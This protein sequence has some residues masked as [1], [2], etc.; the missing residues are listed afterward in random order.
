VEKLFKGILA[1]FDV[2]PEEHHD[3]AR[4]L[5]Q[6]RLLDRKTADTLPAISRLT[7]YAAQYRY[8]PRPGRAHGLNK[9][10]VLRDLET[11]REACSILER[12]LDSRLD[13]LKADSE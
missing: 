5:A 7:P 12:A 11:A 10:D 9:P 1:S 13:S 6:V 4:L 3:L 2:V 8:P